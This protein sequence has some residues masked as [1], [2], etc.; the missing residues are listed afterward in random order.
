MMKTK[1][2]LGATLA[3]LLFTAGAAVTQ[4]YPM[5]DRVAARVVQHYQS[6]TCDQLW[7]E[8]A[9]KAGQPK[10]PMEQRAIQM[11]HEDAGM[12]A[13]FFSQISTPVVTK[14]FECGM[15]P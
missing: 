5:V 13:A 1:L 12:R 9:A 15:I 3:A 10:S 11:L 4:P 7:Q 8:R 14:M 2:W 6:S